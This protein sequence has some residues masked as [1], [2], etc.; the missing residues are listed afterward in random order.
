MFVLPKT[1]TERIDQ[2]LAGRLCTAT[3]GAYISRS[4]GRRKSGRPT[5]YFVHISDDRHYTITAWTDEE[6]IQKANEHERK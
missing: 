5:K 3:T 6:A 2:A 4:G 1:P